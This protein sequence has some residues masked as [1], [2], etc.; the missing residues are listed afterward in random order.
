M[1]CGI[2]IHSQGK[3]SEIY[4]ALLLTYS[5]GIQYNL[6][7]LLNIHAFIEKL[8][9]SAMRCIGLT[10]VVQEDNSEWKVN[11]RPEWPE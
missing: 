3:I 5:M 11:D 8:M 2:C 1:I 6:T 7:V 9:V 4:L 10:K